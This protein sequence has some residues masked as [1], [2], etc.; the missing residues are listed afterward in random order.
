MTIRQEGKGTT[1]SLFAVTRE[2]GPSWIDGQGAFEQPAVK[3][4]ADFM[5][6]LANEGV[7]LFAGPLA[8][9]TTASESF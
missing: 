9:G 4:H 7:V 8:A 6:G 5:D 3:D 1:L 2:A